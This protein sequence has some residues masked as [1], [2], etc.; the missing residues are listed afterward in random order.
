MS[1]QTQFMQNYLHDITYVITNMPILSKFSDS[2]SFAFELD[3]VI[4]ISLKHFSF[5]LLI[6]TCLWFTKPFL[7]NIQKELK[8]Q[9]IKCK[10]LKRM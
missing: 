2:L 1:S 9:I 10:K 3:N 6:L 8:K 5:L 7:I 4:T